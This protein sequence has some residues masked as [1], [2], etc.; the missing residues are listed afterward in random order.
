MRY[1]NL[2]DADDTVPEFEF[3][4]VNF[5]RYK[6]GSHNAVLKALILEQYRKAKS[7][8]GKDVQFST[9]TEDGSLDTTG[10]CALLGIDTQSEV[11]VFYNDIQI[12]SFS[13]DIKIE[14][15]ELHW[16]GKSE[17]LTSNELEPVIL[18][19]GDTVMTGTGFSASGISGSF[20]FRGEVQG[21]I[22]TKDSD[23][24]KTE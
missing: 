15:Q 1:D 22:E 5:Y 18:K 12:E 6:G 19:K 10:S 20:A 7:S 2:S 17:Q 16:N 4:N 14:A 21:T 3:S 9:W 8:Y 13:N 11:Y 23:E 24:G